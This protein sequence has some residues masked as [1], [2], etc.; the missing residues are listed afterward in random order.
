MPAA[1]PVV[2]ETEVAHRPFYN[3]PARITPE[4]VQ[5]PA[6]NWS[7]DS[8]LVVLYLLGVAIGIAWWLVGMAALMRILWTARVAPPHCRQLLAQ[9]AGPHSDRV[10]VLTSHLAK[11]PFAATLW[12]PAKGTGPCFRTQS[13]GQT[14]LAAEKWT[15]P[16]LVQSAIVLPE[17]LRN[18][19][20]A[21]RWALAHEWTH[22]ERRHFRAWFVAG[23][24][25]VLFFYQPL[26][27]WLRRQLRL[28][29]DYVADAHASRAAHG[30][31]SYQSQ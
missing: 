8:W 5:T 28:C 2:P 19:E 12:W 3:L 20:R 23:L 14:R 27:W 15:S 1:A 31:I 21:V 13:T 26:V 17:N 11:Q 30:A 9:I 22:I 4:P 29:Q 7:V 10:R 24:V 18:D 6:Q 16:R 25:R